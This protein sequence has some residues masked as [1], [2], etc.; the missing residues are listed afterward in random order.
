MNENQIMVKGGSAGGL[1][2]PQEVKP[3]GGPVNLENQ[4]EIGCAVSF[5]VEQPEEGIKVGGG[6]I[7][8]PVSFSPES[9]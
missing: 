2:Y 4:L 9:K 7:G 6:V 5:A 8:G 1:L 3:V